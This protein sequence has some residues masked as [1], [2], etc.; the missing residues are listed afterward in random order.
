M[1]GRIVRAAREKERLRERI[2][3][4][5]DRLDEVEIERKSAEIVARV[6]GLASWGRARRR[7]LF[8]SFGSEVRTDALIEETLISGARL[9]LP[10]VRGAE[11]PLALHE[12]RDPQQELAPGSFGIPEPD[13]IRCPEVSAYDLDFVLIPG[14]AF[15]RGGGRLGYGGGFYDYIL[16]LRGDLLEEGA[17]VAV[18]FALQIVDGVPQEGWDVRVPL[19]ATEDELINTRDKGS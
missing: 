7:L 4:R 6:M 17:A 8:C 10:R 18:G 13:E 11:E 1:A 16:N 2:R 12:V 5:R 14:L 3:R 9:V 15:D 19:I